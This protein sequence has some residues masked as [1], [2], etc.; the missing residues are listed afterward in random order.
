MIYAAHIHRKSTIWT[1]Q[2]RLWECSPMLFSLSL[3]NAFET[4]LQKS[5]CGN[6]LPCVSVCS[7]MRFSELPWTGSFAVKCSSVLGP[8][9]L[10]TRNLTLGTSVTD[11]HTKCHDVKPILFPSL[12]GCQSALPRLLCSPGQA[13]LFVLCGAKK[14]LCN[15]TDPST[16]KKSQ[17]SSSLKHSIRVIFPKVLLVR[18]RH[19]TLQRG[20]IV[21]LSRCFQ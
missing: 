2:Y 11:Y 17:K 7:S 9:D 15:M 3:E 1:H 8:L 12:L 16:Q 19:E 4:H 14:K 5:P 10:W 21:D 13:S 20:K 6:E 18:H